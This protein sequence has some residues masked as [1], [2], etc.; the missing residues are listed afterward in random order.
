MCLRAQGKYRLNMKLNWMT[1]QHQSL[2]LAEESLTQLNRNLKNCFNDLVVK[3]I[4]AK[5]EEPTPWV[6]NIVL[7]EKSNGDLR[8]CLDPV[9]LNK[10]ITHDRFPIP[11]VDELARN[12][13]NKKVFTVLD[14]RDAFYHIQLE[15]KSSYYC[16][17]ITPFGKYRYKRLPFGIVVSPEVCQRVNEKIFDGIDVGIYFDDFIISGVDEQD[18]DNKLKLVMNRAKENG[19]K[20]NKNKI[21]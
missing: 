2:V 14:M 12:L 4:I 11:T 10:Y 1:M 6:H 21:Q 9:H 18:H 19:I 16:T 17:F 20:F 13:K 8:M 5:V 15:E 3:D 7:V